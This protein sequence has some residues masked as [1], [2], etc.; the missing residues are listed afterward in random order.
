MVIRATVIHTSVGLCLLLKQLTL[1]RWATQAGGVTA[2]KI[3]MS[4]SVKQVDSA[5]PLTATLWD[6]RGHHSNTSEQAEDQ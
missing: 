5:A 4:V 6:L 2:K 3:I 1:E